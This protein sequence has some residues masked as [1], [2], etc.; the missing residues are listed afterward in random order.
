LPDGR[1]LA[2]KPADVRDRGL[3]AGDGSDSDAR[4]KSFTLPAVND[5]AV[6]EY[7]YI[8][9]QHA[10]LMPGQFWT[11]W[12]FQ[13]G[14]DPVSLSRLSV[15]APKNLLP[16][17]AL[18]NA[19]IS[20]TTRPGKA[21]NTVTQ[22][23]EAT[24]VPAIEFEPLMPDPDRIAPHLALS[25]LNSWQ[26]VAGWY[27]KLAQGRMTPDTHIKTLVAELTRGKTSPEEKARAIF[28]HVEE[29]T[30]YVALEYGIGGYQP[31]PASDV[32]R[33]QF[34]DCKDMTTLLVAMLREAGIAA[35]PVL[36]RAGSTARVRDEL[37][38]PGAFNHAICLA[39][40]NG[41]KY[42]LD[43]TAGLATFGVTP[44]GDRGCDVLVIRDGKGDFETIPP[45][46]PD[47][48]R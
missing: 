40:I 21:P 34:G 15:T 46:A 10:P 39:E 42:W 11:K 48:T 16:K 28:Y 22:V 14:R 27:W 17:Q 45:A 26:D 32:F 47:E 12:W 44:G 37:P 38:T 18:K 41:K 2:I 23:W 3:D 33:N 1:V 13:T 29:K 4:V 30:R 8:T 31:R 43:A 20:P 19:A 7:E 6:L 5:G 9:D 25:T 24:D 36:L 35:H